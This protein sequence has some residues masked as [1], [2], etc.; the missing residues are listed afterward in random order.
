MPSERRRCASTRLTILTIWVMWELN[1]ES[2][3]SMLCS[4][5]M[6]AQTFAK[7]ETCEPASAGIWRPDMAI[8][9]SSP[10]VFRHTV[11]PPVLGPVMTSVLNSSPIQMLVGTTPSSDI[12]GWRAERRL[13]TPSAVTSGATAAILSDSEAFA[14]TESSMPSVTW[15]SAIASEMA[16][17]R[18]VSACS[19]ASSSCRISRFVSRSRLPCST[20]LSGSMNTVAPDAERS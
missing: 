1:V 20:T 19:S 10:M 11:L 15:S 4:S 12:S 14:A 5:P 9:V 18:S 16:P 7:T 13:V 3:C 8:S 2:D 6:S 17:T